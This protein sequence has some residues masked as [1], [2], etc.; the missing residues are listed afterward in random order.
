MNT[1][2]QSI[3]TFL[4]QSGF[5][6]AA[7]DIVANVGIPLESVLSGEG[8]LRG[9]RARH[10][11]W[12]GLYGRG[13]GIFQIAP[14][15][16]R[17][18]NT[19]QNGIVRHRQRA[20][21]AADDSVRLVAH[22][23]LKSLKSTPYFQVIREVAERHGVTPLAICDNRQCRAAAKARD[24]VW[25]LLR[26]QMAVPVTEQA[27]LFGRVESTIRVGIQRH[28]KTVGIH[29]SE[30]TTEPQ[31]QSRAIAVRR[32][33]TVRGCLE[34]AEEMASKRGVT[35]ED[36]CMPDRGTEADRARTELWAWLRTEKGLSK[37]AIAPMF[38]VSTRTVYLHL[39]NSLKET[40]N[41]TA[42]RQLANPE[43]VERLLR[44]YHVYDSVLEVVTRYGTTL[45][46]IC[47]WAERPNVARAR[48]EVFA[49]LVEKHGF[50]R[51]DAAAFFNQN[52]AAVDRALRKR[53]RSNAAEAAR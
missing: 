29:D 50:S 7:R 24:E 33:L 1:D 38:G 51:G 11:I 52:D 18:L 31:R 22:E 40:P 49:T 2:I 5:E 53:R 8:G 4:Q 6:Q 12:A 41:R 36:L 3:L 48:W 21:G 10:A 20:G 35:F 13:V 39:K 43:S 17:P 42:G 28:L 37:A 30:R 15:F 32:S 23:R 47:F 25:H 44:R 46:E 16:G 45:E 19:I 27:L 34:H 9:I 14:A 26:E